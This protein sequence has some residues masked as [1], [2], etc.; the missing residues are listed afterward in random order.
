MSINY[1]QEKY[2]KGASKISYDEANSEVDVSA[3][4]NVTGT[5]TASDV[6]TLGNGLSPIAGPALAS[7]TDLADD[8]AAIA[9]ATTDL[10][11][12]FLCLLD[13]AAKTV[14]LPTV[15]SAHVGGQIAII[16]NASLVGSGIL[17]LSAG[18]GTFATNSYYIG[19]NGG[20]GLFIAATRPAAANN[21]ITITGAATNSAWGIGSV[22]VFTV[23]A[24][25][26]WCF[27]AK[28]EAIGTGSDA[29][30]YSTV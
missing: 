23:Q 10:G 13:G 14:T 24:A 22:I 6:L 19:M 27:Q 28:A 4:M 1:G 18:A 26:E 5:V 25:G 17:T 7:G 20:A 16:Q 15:T 11:K 2:A 12:T 9:L 30:A 21:T 3:N 29:V 8:T